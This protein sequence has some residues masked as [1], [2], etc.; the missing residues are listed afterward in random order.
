MPFS[1]QLAVCLSSGQCWHHIS[2]RL[3]SSF[4]CRYVQT[5]G[6][7]L[8]QHLS[9]PLLPCLAFCIWV[10]T[11]ILFIV[12]PMTSQLTD[13]EAAIEA[14]A[15]VDPTLQNFIIRSKHLVILD[16]SN[17]MWGRLMIFW[18]QLNDRDININYWAGVAFKTVQYGCVCIAIL[19]CTI[20]SLRRLSRKK[21]SFLSQRTLTLYR[22]LTRILIIDACF[23]FGFSI[24]P[25][26]G[27]AVLVAVNSRFCKLMDSSR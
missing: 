19:Y 3:N 12:I 24:M 22:Q 15:A 10:T 6:G 26:A 14:A 8:V 27:L 2:S 7:R 25:L 18:V 4:T 23:G 5:V 1:L 17:E 20:G 11:P 16:V 13:K 21:L 9:R